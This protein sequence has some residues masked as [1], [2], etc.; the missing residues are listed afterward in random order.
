M[1]EVTYENIRKVTNK[2]Y[3]RLK[4]L[5]LKL[6]KETQYDL[7]DVEKFI[8]KLNYVDALIYNDDIKRFEY[9]FSKYIDERVGIN[10]N[11]SREDILI[12][13]LFGNL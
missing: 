12:K 1:L 5:A 6:A 9:D 11:N 4:N 8:L 7:R 3:Y 13:R 10:Y 2:K